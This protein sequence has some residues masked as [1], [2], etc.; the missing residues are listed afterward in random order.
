MKKRFI[1]LLLLCSILLSGCSYVEKMLYPNANN[2]VL[3]YDTVT[4]IQ[5]TDISGSHYNDLF[6]NPLISKDMTQQTVSSVEKR[7]KLGESVNYIDYKSNVSGDDPLSQWLQKST[8]SYGFSGPTITENHIV[9]YMIKPVES[10]SSYHDYLYIMRALTLKYGECTT[11]IYRKANG[12]VF[13]PIARQEERTPQEM[14]EEYSQAF[15]QELMS[16]SG[17]WVDKDYSIAIEFKSPNDCSI[18]YEYNQ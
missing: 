2:A 16:V 4:S 6:L 13:N 1:F 5:K 12:N 18:I 3:Y 8:C 14:I 7:T 10:T 15:S 11:E 17:R 9:Y